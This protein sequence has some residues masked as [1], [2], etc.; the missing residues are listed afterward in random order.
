MQNNLRPFN[1]QQALAEKPV[2]TRDGRTIS[3]LHYL[4]TSNSKQRLI[5]VINGLTCFYDDNGKYNYQEY[6]TH[7]DLFMAPET[8]TKWVNVYD[9]GDGYETGQVLLYDT[10]EYAKSNGFQCLGYIATVPITFIV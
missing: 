2:V 6:E 3:E 10:E 7:H 1:L 4:K 9:K 8:I 5:A